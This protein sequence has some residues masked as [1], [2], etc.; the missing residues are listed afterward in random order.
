MLSKCP[1]NKGFS[2]IELMI[3][4][5]IVAIILSLAAPSFGTWIKN[6]QVRT[7][8]ETLKN[9]IQFAQVEAARRSRQVTFSL[10][11]SAPGLSVTAVA[12]GTN[13]SVQ[14]LP[15]MTGE[16]AEFIQGS[17]VDG[18]KSGIVIAGVA[19][20]TFN[21]LGRLSGVP[22]TATY[23]ISKVGSDRPLRVTVTT[24]GR[25]R[26]CDPSLTMSTTTPTGC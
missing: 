10:T 17:Y 14:T 20:I 26:M 24:N 4:L 19:T 11:N 16:V 5:A 25:V 7:V 12:T 23:N 1:R 21:S 2:L 18:A 9:G 6:T 3:T 8:A 13:W 15:L 22:A